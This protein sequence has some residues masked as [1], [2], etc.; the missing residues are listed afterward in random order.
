[1]RIFICN[2]LPVVQ[3]G[4]K[5]AL[6]AS[7]EISIV[8]ASGSGVETM[9]TVRRLRPHVVILDAALP[10]RTGLELLRRLRREALEPPPRVL[11]YTLDDDDETAF[12]ALEA[13]ATGY[14]RKEANEQDLVNAVYAVGRGSVSLSP[15]VME[16]VLDWCF[17]R[18]NLPPGDF[19]DEVRELTAR[20]REVLQLVS[21]G[22]SSEEIAEELSLGLATVRTHTYR[23]RQKLKLRDRA[24]LVSFAFRSGIVQP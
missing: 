3:R 12:Q 8:G 13:G 17:R 10:G 21:R 7:S 14:L 23:L 5:T 22:L 20:E 24:Q 1:M 18:T 4:L 2:E 6:E 15:S 9:H 11:V 16:C 19:P